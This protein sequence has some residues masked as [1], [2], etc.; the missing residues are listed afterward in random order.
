MTTAKRKALQC[1]FAFLFAI[2]NLPL[3]YII[4]LHDLETVM[5]I[6][7]HAPNQFLFLFL[8]LPSAIVATY[9]ALDATMKIAKIYPQIRK[10]RIW[11]VAFKKNI[12]IISSLVIA[13]GFATVDHFSTPPDFYQYER[14]IA[15]KAAR[16]NNE[17][18][19]AM[20][21]THS[22]EGSRRTHQEKMNQN[23]EA[24]RSLYSDT[25]SA[26]KIMQLFEFMELSAVG[27]LVSLLMWVGYLNLKMI[28]FADSRLEQ[29]EEKHEMKKRLIQ[30]IPYS[31]VAML[32][33]LFWPPLR[34]YNIYE[35]KKVF[36][37]Y[38]TMDPTFGYIIAAIL[39]IT[40]CWI[41]YNQANPKFFKTLT[42]IIGF[43][44]SG[45]LMGFV[46]L[47]PESL[48]DY[49]GSGM[50]MGDLFFLV[51]V[52]GLAYLFGLEIFR[53]VRGKFT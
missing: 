50:S 11:I 51:F 22:D 42:A 23:M 9:G 53:Q 18:I 35:I 13:L 16:L 46:K 38:Q 17:I 4:W 31:V 52:I 27:L 19:N 39:S 12:L 33:F 2:A 48:V 44:A 36:T 20:V 45:A 5:K 30:I 29:E 32:A 26:D 7:G 40:L 24:L 1:C 34:L 25:S 3:L 21:Q 6:V 43:F 15:R 49:I 28:R 8:L 10:E 14:E 41:Y 47:A 37:N